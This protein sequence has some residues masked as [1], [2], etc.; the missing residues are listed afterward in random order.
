MW[1]SETYVEDH[2]WSSEAHV[3]GTLVQGHKQEER[4]VNVLSVLSSPPKH[5]TDSTTTWR[6]GQVCRICCHQIRY[7]LK[8]RKV[9]RSY[10]TMWDTCLRALVP[11]GHMTL[12]HMSSETYV[13]L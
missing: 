5:M 4:C 1:L 9:P 3:G 8:S 2:Q 10:P 6:R 12:R 11:W 13:K 7:P